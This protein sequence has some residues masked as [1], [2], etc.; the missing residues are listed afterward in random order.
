MK[1][2]IFA[3]L[4]LVAVFVTV[5]A[6]SVKADAASMRYQV[7]YAIKDMNPWLDYNDHSK[8]LNLGLFNLTG[9]GD[10]DE[11]PLGGLFDDNG[12]GVQGEGD[13]LYTTA[14][15]VTDPYGKTIIYITIDSL[16]G[17][18]YVTADARTA[19][20]E[21]LGSDVIAPEEIMVSGS[22]THSG[23]YF[24]G[25]RTATGAKG[26]YYQYIISQITAAAVEAYND[27]AEAVMSKGTINAKESTA[28]LGYNGGKGYHMN[29]IR[30]YEVT[31]TNKK[32]TTQ[33]KSYM[34]CSG[35]GLNKAA[36]IPYYP[37]H[38][39][40]EVTT[41]T[42]D[43]NMHV[44]KFDFP[45]DSTKEPV[46]F[47]NWRAHTTMNSGVNKTLLSSDYVNGLRTELKKNR[48]RAA[49]LQGAAGNVV[50]CATSSTWKTNAEDKDWRNYA[51]DENTKTYIYGTM[52]AK[53]AMAHREKTDMGKL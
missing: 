42:S 31:V 9:N 29:A 39:K 27:R 43:N 28:H 23:G 37:N 26:A 2:R 20:V 33:S 19:I 25:M 16:Q 34:V 44:L 6:M 53:I 49:F 3:M 8:G 10:D 1:K 22:H 18:S 45:N 35:D 14:T 52:L 5:V 15:A 51:P 24:Q 50:T 7:G 36:E 48:Y 21:K 12:D 32:D 38:S 46:V 40:S 30:H 47:V 11:R 17:Y 13:G 4:C 41:D